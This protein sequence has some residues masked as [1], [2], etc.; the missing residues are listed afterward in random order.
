MIPLHLKQTVVCK[1]GHLK[2]SQRNAT[3]LKSGQNSCKLS[4]KEFILIQSS[5]LGYTSFRNILQKGSLDFESTFI[6]PIVHG[7]VNLPPLSDFL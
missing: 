5:V 6:N 4:L 1:T 3:Y 2:I 7:G